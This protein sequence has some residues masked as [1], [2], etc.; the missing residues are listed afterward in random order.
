MK[1]K[2][3]IVLILMMLL[4]MPTMVGAVEVPAPTPQP[5]PPTTMPIDTPKYGPT[6]QELP[7]GWTIRKA[8]M[9][10]QYGLDDFQREYGARPVYMEIVEISPANNYAILEFSS[11]A[12][13]E[14]GF[15]SIIR[16]EGWDSGDITY[17]FGDEGIFLPE[18]DVNLIFRNDNFV[19]LIEYIE[20]RTL[21]EIIDEK[22]EKFILPMPFTISNLVIK[23]AKVAIGKPVTIAV[24]VTNTGYLEDT[25]K[26]ILII[27]EGEIETKDVTVAGGATE[28]G[29][30]SPVTKDAIGIYNVA[31]G[32]QA[33]RFRVLKS[34]A[35]TV[36]NLVISPVE[37]ET[38]KP[39]KI[40]VDIM[41][42]GE[43]K[44][45]YTVML[46]I[47][48]AEVET[49]AVTVA[50]EATETVSFTI[51]KDEIR[52]YSVDVDGQTGSFTVTEQKPGLSG[53]EAVFAIAGLL[54]V[55]YLIGRKE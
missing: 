32:D 21:A 38:G 4:V 45:V 53:F 51:I 47:D 15:S 41:N 24:D 48:G 35:F 22:L 40:A 50:P 33:G 30:F 5:L 42:T 17:E 23:P 2:I 36:R 52:T 27:D 14:A 11:V 26:A 13:A 20:P 7:Y 43:T 28:T 39:V 10:N 49:I 8:E 9:Y 16:V 46:W 18:E 1:F 3:G 19:V 34:A 44:D 37:V 55:A 31:V 25:Y 54:A 29:S 6:A 12:D